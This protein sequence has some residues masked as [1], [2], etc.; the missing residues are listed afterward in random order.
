MVSP[1]L[2]EHRWGGAYLVSEAR[3][4]RARDQVL[5]KQQNP[6][7][8]IVDGG[9]VLGQILDGTAAVFAMVAGATGN[10][11]SG[12]IVIGAG[13]IEGV[14]AG[15]MRDATHFDLFNPNGDLVGEGV[16]AAPFVGGGL[17]FTLTAGGTACVVGDKF[18]IT[19]GANAD[20][21]KYV[22]LNLAAADGSQ[23]AAAIMY[24]TEDVSQADT[25]ITVTVR[26][27]EVNGGELTYPA[28]ATALQIAAINQQ[29][30]LLGIIVR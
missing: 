28:G 12:A 21:N 1:V 27:S 20:V 11:T 25:K 13:V 15:E 19:M 6:A 3:G 7:G 29:L 17:T 14:Y 4:E 22:P 24:N 30:K 23:I 18:T 9:T 16:F 8:T 26:A 10:P 5:M 2:T